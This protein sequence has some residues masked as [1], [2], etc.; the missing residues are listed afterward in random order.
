MPPLRCALTVNGPLASSV[1]DMIRKR[2]DA[3]VTRDG[4]R[5]V[6]T[7]DDV[8]Q[9]AVRAATTMLWDNGHEVV[10]MSLTPAPAAVR[11]P[12]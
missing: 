9:A 7:V 10:A 5:T 2:F 1:V 6:L 4:D 11:G 12:R 3:V 8:D